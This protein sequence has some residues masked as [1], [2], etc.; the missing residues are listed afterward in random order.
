[1]ETTAQNV[2]V[3]IL[4]EKKWRHLPESCHKVKCQKKNSRKILTV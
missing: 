2:R 1:M 3:E 4:R